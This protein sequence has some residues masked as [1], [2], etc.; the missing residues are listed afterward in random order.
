[1]N[2]WQEKILGRIILRAV[3]WEEERD[4]LWN[5]TFSFLPLV[6]ILL[7][8]GFFSPLREDPPWAT[9][10]WT[11][12]RPLPQ[13]SPTVRAHSLAPSHLPLAGPELSRRAARAS[14]VERRRPIVRTSVHQGL[15]ASIVLCWRPQ[16]RAGI[17]APIVLCWRPA[18]A[19][20]CPAY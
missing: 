18:H 11:T 12:V 3:R 6:G 15:R 1:M 2:P 17:R 8:P 5:F 13:F 16:R 9:T 14:R 10:P 20:N 19:S 4:H 7:P